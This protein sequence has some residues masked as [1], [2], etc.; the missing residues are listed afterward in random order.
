MGRSVLRFPFSAFRLL[1]GEDKLRA[2]CAGVIGFVERFPR[3]LAA[4]GS[5]RERWGRRERMV[6]IGKFLFLAV[7]G[8]VLLAAVSARAQV[9]CD[10]FPNVEVH[11]EALFPDPYVVDSTP[12]A[13]LQN[14]ARSGS[15]SIREGWTLGLT[16]Y[17][18]VIEIRLPVALVQ[19]EGGLAC[20]VANALD[21]RLGYKDVVVYVAREIP[22]HTCGFDE[23]FRHEMKHV[24]ANRAVLD[25]YLPLVSERL[26]EHLKFNGVIR[27]EN[28]DYA[29]AVLQDKLREIVER[30]MQE[31]DRENAVRQ[32]A[33]DSRDEYMRISQACGGQLQ[34]VLGRFLKAN[35]HGR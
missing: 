29:V 19:T 25:A 18:P 26:R 32:A 3:F 30:T 31:M 5:H 17:K 34:G 13:T 11:I 10:S 8:A 4:V 24:E 6:H 23:V 14:L 15:H 20:A 22:Q 2:A 35:G 21:V 1:R 12:L 27:Q 9:A 33:I 7:A 16:T 28:P